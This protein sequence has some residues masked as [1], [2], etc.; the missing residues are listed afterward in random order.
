MD[1]MT[2][3]GTVP[4]K[5]NAYRII[6]VAGHA[7]LGKSK[8]LK[9]YERAF[10]LQMGAY[11]NLGLSGLFELEVRVFYPS[12]RSDLD[13]ALKILLDCLQA[14]GA[15]ANDNKCVRITAEKFIDRERP[16]VELRLKD[17]NL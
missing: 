16:R 17:L 14:G 10:Y 6:T 7:S 13:N 8:A 5:A 4:S 11:R 3:K 12:M 9:D 15:I 2:I 1:W